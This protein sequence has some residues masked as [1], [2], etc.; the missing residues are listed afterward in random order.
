MPIRS[1]AI[2]HTLQ[3]YSGE[4]IYGHGD[5][6]QY[7]AVLQL[8]QSAP[9]YYNMPLLHRQMIDV[10]GVKNANKLAEV[11]KE[12]GINV[13]SGGTDKHLVLIEVETGK[14]GEIAQALEDVGIIVNKNTVPGEKGSPMHP[15]GVR[16]GT[17]AI[18]VRGMKEPQME[19]IGGYILRV[20]EVVGTRIN[21][22]K[23]MKEIGEK[24]LALAR[25]FPVPI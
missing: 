16:M 19:E 3:K 12:G 6:V 2:I 18:T 11:L 9:Q 10:L 22:E 14:G 24:V 25:K 8:A 7:Q 17:P 5:I 15:S 20:I 21:Y 13:I 4:D 23:E 1:L